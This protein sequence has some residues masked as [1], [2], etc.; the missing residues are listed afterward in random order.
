MNKLGGKIKI[1]GRK[2]IIKRQR[3]LKKNINYRIIFDR[4]EAG[5]YLVAGILAGE[6]IKINDVKPKILKCEIDTLK[7][8]GAKIKI[9]KSSIEVKRIKYLKN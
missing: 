6:K 4:I 5:T 8:M 7:K 9:G 1:F 3:L 2:I